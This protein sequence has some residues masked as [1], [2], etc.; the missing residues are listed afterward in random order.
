MTNYYYLATLLPEI[1]IGMP[2]DLDSSEMKTLIRENVT[3]EDIRKIQTALRYFDIQ[4]IRA[5]WKEEPFDPLGNYDPVEMEE[6]L[7][8]RLGLPDYVY[9]YMDTYT[10]VEERVA[11]FSKLVGLFF[12]HEIDQADGFMKE[13][14]TL[15]R[16][17]RLI[18][19]AFRAKKLGRDVAH[20]LQ[21]EANGNDVVSQIIAQKDAKS[22]E[23]PYRYS[24]MKPIFET[25][26][27]EPLALNQ[28]LC[29]YRFKKINEFIGVD[30]FSIEKIL[31]YIAK[32]LIAEKWL[33]LDK[34]KGM[35]VIDHIVKEA[36]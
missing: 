33:A 31:A 17:W 8:T 28:A 36:S 3:K 2:V 12:E 35:E 24:D 15:E 27:D 29:E 7:I 32:L 10:E 14:L 21:F 26:Q 30:L 25:Y 13:Y 19:T 34:Q 20:E 16:D 22:Y 23:P 6:M 9:D 18:F 5:F 11:N 1:Q 4:N